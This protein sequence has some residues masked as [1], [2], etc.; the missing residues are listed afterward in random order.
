MVFFTIN[1]T[2][3]HCLLPHSI[4]NS[5]YS[6][7]N[8]SAKIENNYTYS[9][10]FLSFFQKN[11]TLYCSVLIN[12]S[13]YLNKMM[14]KIG[15]IIKEQVESSNMEVTTFAKAIKKERSNIYDIFKRSSIDTELLKKIGQVLNH[16][17]FEDLLEPETRA[18]LMI[19]GGVTKKILVEVELTEEEMNILNI[20]NK[21]VGG[22]KKI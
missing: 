17:F 13:L 8:N 2:N 19:K 6:V 15:Q 16:D 12:K 22:F 11:S 10:I 20:N 3:I 14:K 18:K 21:V 1:G 5:Y 9:Q 7:Q 4:S